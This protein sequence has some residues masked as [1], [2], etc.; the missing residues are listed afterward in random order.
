MKFRTE[1]KAS[2]APFSLSPEKPVVLMG[3]CFSQNMAQKMKQHGWAASLPGG[4][5]YNP[6]SIG[7]AIQILNDK[8]Q[9]KNKFTESLFQTNGLWNS[10]KFDSS[11]SGINKEDCI[12]EFESRQKDFL[13]SLHEGQTLIVTFGTSIC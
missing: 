5:L 7:T 6:L 3:S 12:L 4:T 13:N 8:E 10:Y 2:K 11:F 9:G 1:Y